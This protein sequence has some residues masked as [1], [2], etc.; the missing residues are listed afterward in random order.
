MTDWKSLL[1]EVIE[2]QLALRNG[3]I[4]AICNLFMSRYPEELESAKEDVFAAALH[5][6]CKSLMKAM[7]SDEKQLEISGISLPSAIAI[8]K[9]DGEYYYVLSLLATWE[10][11]EQGRKTRVENIAAA[12]QSLGRYDETM[13]RLRPIMIKS[14]GMNVGD[15]LAILASGAEAA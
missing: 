11:I 8:K 14:P 1:R 5:R 9:D 12:Q 15:A 2:E 6:T 10:E 13:L 7:S 3:E 4:P